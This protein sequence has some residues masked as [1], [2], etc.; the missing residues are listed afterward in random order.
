V[1]AT[2]HQYLENIKPAV[3]ADGGNIAFDL[4]TK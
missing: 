1:T 2:N 3:Q 4:T